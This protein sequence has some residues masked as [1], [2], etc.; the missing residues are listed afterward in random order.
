MMKKLMSTLLV[1]DI[2]TMPVSASAG[3]AFKKVGGV[4]V[5]TF[6]GAFFSG[7]VRGA[8]DLETR[9]ADGL[10]DAFGGGTVAKAFGYPI[11]AFAGGFAGGFVGLANGAASGVVY[12]LKDPFS[13]E[14]LSLAGDFHDYDVLDFDFE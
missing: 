3:S 12:G 2:I 4:I 1:A 7:P 13:E 10:A 8:H 6:Y 5:G 14:N 11:G 9:G